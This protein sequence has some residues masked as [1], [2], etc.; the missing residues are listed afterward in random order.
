MYFIP[1]GFPGMTILVMEDP[2]DE[3]E[4]RLINEEERL[5]IVKKLEKEKE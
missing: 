2:I 5:S 1:S 4:C 3:V